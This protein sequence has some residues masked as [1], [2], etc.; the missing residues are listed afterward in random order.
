VPAVILSG[1]FELRDFSGNGGEET[2]LVGLIV[3]TILA[4]VVGYASIAF[5]LRYLANHSTYVFVAYRVVLGTAVIALA[6]AGAIS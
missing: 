4:F 3:A 5:L 1:L 2:G 6:A